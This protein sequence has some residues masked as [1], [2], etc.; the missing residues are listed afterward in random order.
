PSVTPTITPIVGA[1]TLT[2]KAVGAA[3]IYSA[4]TAA[5][6]T[7]N[8]VFDSGAAGNVTLHANIGETK[9]GFANVTLTGQHDK[10]VLSEGVFI[11]SKTIKF[12]DAAS[13]ITLG[14]NSALNAEL[15]N[16]GGEGNLIIADG[17]SAS[18]GYVENAK[19]LK[20]VTFGT[21][22]GNLTKLLVGTSAANANYSFGVKTLDLTKATDATAQFI[23]DMTKLPAGRSLTLTVGGG[24]NAGITTTAGAGKS[25]GALVFENNKNGNKITLATVGGAVT[26]IGGTG[27]VAGSLALLDAAGSDLTIQSNLAGDLISIDNIKAEKLTLTK[28]G[29]IDTNFTIKGTELTATENALTINAEGQK[30]T[31]AAG[32]NLGKVNGVQLIKNSTL[33]FADGVNLDFTSNV[34]GSTNDQAKLLFTGTSK[35]T[36]TGTLGI[37]GKVL[38][39][40]EVHGGNSK[41]VTFDTSDIYGNI[42]Y[43]GNSVVGNSG[44]VINGNVH[45]NITT[46]NGARGHVTFS[47]TSV[48]DGSVGAAEKFHTVEIGADVTVGKVTVDSTYDTEWTTF[49]KDATLT[50][51]SKIKGA[52]DST[53]GTVKTTAGKGTGTIKFNNDFTVNGNIGEDGAEL[54]S[55]V[56]EANKALTIGGAATTVFADVLTST[57]GQGTVVVGSAHAVTINGDVG[58]ANANFLSATIGSDNLTTVKDIHGKKVSIAAAGG[59][60]VTAV[61][62]NSADATDGVKFT[63]DGTL[64]IKDAGS[65][66]TFVTTD[67]DGEGS[68][69]FEGAGTIGGNLGKA[70]TA[71]NALTLGGTLD[72]KV[73]FKGN[74]IHLADASTQSS[75]LELT[76]DTTIKSGGDYTING[77]AI[78]IGTNDLLFNGKITVGAN[79]ATFNVDANRAYVAKGTGAAVGGGAAF[80]VASAGNKVTIN[81][82]GTATDFPKNHQLK[83]L[84]VNGAGA[85][86]AITGAARANVNLTAEGVSS[87]QNA[88]FG[89][90]YVDAALVAA[91][92]GTPDKD[93]LDKITAVNKTAPVA[94]QIYYVVDVNKDKLFDSTVS[95][96]GPAASE[97]AQAFVDQIDTISGDAAKFLAGLNGATVAERTA[98]LQ[99]VSDLST[100]TNV[101]GQVAHEA[102]SSVLNASQNRVIDL[103]S[104]TFGGNDVAGVAAGD[105]ASS[106]KFGVWANVMGGQS[107]QKLRKNVAGYQSKTLA[108]MVGADTM[109]SDKALVGML[110]GNASGNVKHKDAKTGDKTKSSSW[111]FGVYGSYDIGQTDFF[112][113]G[114]FTVAQTAVKSKE[115]RDHFA[116]G[117]KTAQTASSKYDVLGYGAQVLAGYKHSFSNSYVI[118][119]AGLGFSYLGDVSYTTTGA[120]NQNTKVTTKST[121]VLSALA[122]VKF[123]TMVDMDGTTLMP[124]VHMNGSYALNSPS[125]KG[126][127][128]L[129]G[130]NGPIQYK[131]PKAAKFGYNFGTSVMAQSD[132]IEYGIGYDADISDKYLAHQGSLKFKVKF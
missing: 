17:A 15:T 2:L 26:H 24:A 115:G 74:Q 118:P 109:L 85:P 102:I 127:F 73:V 57:A 90:H 119:T 72:K 66:N 68:L 100:A 25:A 58:S 113:Q 64:T 40:I 63:S 30:V 34:A 59:G 95:N 125:A 49:T 48:V 54:K 31:L 93:A 37:S 97:L 39:E 112:L 92:A 51:G 120:T 29:A 14:N 129:N 128:A 35:L 103:S 79:G 106:E 11:N 126:S 62:V 123:G 122:G 130:L 20:S 22:N 50:L 8:L 32:S 99:K 84:F 86:I 43:T 98:A 1:K 83:N 108:A 96:V 101:V 104:L 107:T 91:V 65:I 44:M 23:V 111:L 16:A 82:T 21:A 5:A 28:G 52:A 67:T 69:S 7:A 3:D 110:V 10:L 19:T 53:L 87:A 76:K 131:G 80:E 13:A 42:K 75:T 33:E 132:E 60:N 88:L 121:S 81:A 70:G 47:K 116:N 45:G 77:G 61:N 124:E 71:L 36:G 114:N 89:A 78:N 4:I 117:V 38:N 12:G 41:I 94:G 105:V 6:D 27:G 55:L 9:M 56:M 18:G 46:G